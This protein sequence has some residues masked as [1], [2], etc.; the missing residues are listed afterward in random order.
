MQGSSRS[1]LDEGPNHVNAHLYGLMRGEHIRGLDGP[2]LGECKRQR[3]GKLQLGE[4]VAIC[5]HLGLLGRGQLKH[6]VDGKPLPVALDL[7]V[8]PLGRDAVKAGQ[9]HVNHHPLATHD[10]YAALDLW[11]EVRAHSCG[12]ASVRPRGR[13]G[14]T[15]RR[16]IG[17]EAS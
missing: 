12:L 14:I 9:V 8:E 13:R 7:L 11:P 4:V 16:W 6:E 3:P 5:D 10:V 15:A 17:G 2:M 1:Q